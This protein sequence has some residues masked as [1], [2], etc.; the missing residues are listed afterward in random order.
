MSMRWVRSARSFPLSLPLILVFMLFLVACQGESTP[1]AAATPTS[2]SVETPTSTPTL[3]PTAEGSPMLVLPNIADVVE[4]AG[5]SVVSIAAEI[6]SRDVFRFPRT[7]TSSGTGI[8]FDNQGHILTN[9]HVVQGASR[10]EITLL[11]GR[12]LEAEIVGTDPRTDLA[13]LRVD[14][15]PDIR[16]V[17]LGDSAKLRVGEWVIAIGNALALPGGPTVTVGV[18]SALDRSIPA[19]QNFFLH[20]LIQTDTVINPGNSGGPLLNLNGEVVG[21]NTAVFRGPT[22]TG[23]EVEGIGFAISTE[24][25]IP[26]AQQLIEN[27]RVIFPYLGVIIRDVDP[28][29]ALEMD[30]T[31]RQGILVIDIDPEGPASAAGIQP[32]DVIIALDGRQVDTL[33]QLQQLLR[34]EYKVGQKIVVTVARGEAHLDFP[35]TLAEMPR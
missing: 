31:V 18:V 33:R 28:T 25:A 26:I 8:I 13:V 14:L 5:P 20:N 32:E 4:A 2:P 11:N 3:I 34:A 27:G 22:G 6:Q 10:V 16:P 15:D 19:G 9:N 12:T 17:P 29:T 24:T 23:Q 21:I 30:L 35:L 7:G 1:T